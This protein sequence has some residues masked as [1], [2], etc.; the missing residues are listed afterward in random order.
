LADVLLEEID[1][2]G[3]KFKR[4]SGENEPGQ[5]AAIKLCQLPVGTRRLELPGD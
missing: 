4:M 3:L 5:K 2:M 1:P